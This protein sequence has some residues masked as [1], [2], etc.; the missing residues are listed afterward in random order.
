[1]FSNCSLS[2]VWVFPYCFQYFRF[3]NENTLLGNKLLLE[4]HLTIILLSFRSNPFYEPKPTP[5]PNNLVNAI[6]ELETE[7]RVKRKAPA[8]PAI[9][10]KTG[11]VNENT[12]VSAGRDLSTSPKVGAYS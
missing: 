1:M 3:T 4:E 9:S 2:L 8:P 7:R 11:G 12:A 5:P 10:P 6:Q